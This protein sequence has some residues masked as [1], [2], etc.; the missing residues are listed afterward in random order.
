MRRCNSFGWLWGLV[1]LM[2]CLAQQ[3]VADVSLD[4]VTWGTGG[5]TLGWVGGGDANPVTSPGSG[6]NPDGFLAINFD[7]ADPFTYQTNYVANSGAGYTGNY[8]GLGLKFDLLGYASSLEQV[9]FVSS[10]DG[11]NSTWY[12]TLV[13]PTPL[14]QTWQTYNVSFQQPGSWYTGDSVDFLTALSQVDSI[15][16]IVSQFG[17]DVP[18][19]YGIDNWQFLQDQSQLYVPEPG[20]TAMAVMLLLS[21]AFWGRRTLVARRG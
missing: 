8:T 16:L 19:Q 13:D 2:V 4:P 20:V 7:A 15:G 12:L 18:M 11:T 14:D 9:F 1:S 10:A 21:L 6:G 3:V 17:T 5:N